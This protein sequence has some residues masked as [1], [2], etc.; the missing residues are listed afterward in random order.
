[1]KRILIRSAVFAAVGLMALPAASSAF[2]FGAQINREPSNS[3]PPRSCAQDSNV[4]LASPCTRVLIASENG[5][6]GGN[7]KSPKDGVVTQFRIRAGG[8]GSIRF[9]LVRLRNV[10]QANSTAEGKAHAKSQKFTVQGR[11]FDA[12]NPVESFNV[13]LTVK[14][15]DYV[16]I[17]GSKTTAQRCTQGSPRQLMWSPSLKVGDPFRKND[18][19]ANCTLMVQAV[20]HT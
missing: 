18:A 11:G 20:G 17:E 4:G 2:T 1:M 12:V 8:P 3:T 19:H 13:N 10:N 6:A 16:A 15:G 9:K 7:L 5:F 14:K